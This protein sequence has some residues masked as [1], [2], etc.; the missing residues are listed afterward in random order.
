MDPNDLSLD[1]ISMDSTNTRRK[2]F[3]ILM[4][5]YAFNWLFAAIITLLLIGC[6]LYVLIDEY[7][8]QVY[9]GMSGWAQ[10]LIS[11]FIGVWITD[12]PKFIKT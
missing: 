5:G 3:N 1:K 12:R 6:S 9:T 7:Q 11:F 8:N 2:K 4:L 10:T